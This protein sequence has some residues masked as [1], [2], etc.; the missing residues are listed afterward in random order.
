MYNRRENI[1]K[2]SPTQKKNENFAKDRNGFDE[3]KLPS[4][5]TKSYDVRRSET[6]KRTKEVG[7]RTLPKKQTEISKNPRRKREENR[8]T[9]KEEYAFLS[10]SNALNL[11]GFNMETTNPANQGKIGAQKHSSEEGRSTAALKT[12]DLNMR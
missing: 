12:R 7:T 1:N 11:T 9:F 10:P 3:E 5:Q 8:K 4:D 2:K 6:R